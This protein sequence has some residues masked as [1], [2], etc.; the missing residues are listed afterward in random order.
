[1]VGQ[2]KT[3]PFQQQETNREVQHQKQ[4]MHEQKHIQQVGQHIGRTTAVGSIMKHEYLSFGLSKRERTQWPFNCMQPKQVARHAACSGGEQR[5]LHKSLQQRH[6]SKQCEGSTRTA[7][8]RADG[9]GHNQGKRLLAHTNSGQR[10]SAGALQTDV[11]GRLPI[12]LVCCC[13]WRG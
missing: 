3:S 1:M 10:A 9:V 4:L 11:S 13:L 2:K 7:Q 12:L 8:Q 5:Y 6:E